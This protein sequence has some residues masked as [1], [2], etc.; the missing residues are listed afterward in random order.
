MAV[1]VEETGRVE[2][3][4]VGVLAMAAGEH[5]AAGRDQCKRR[6]PQKKR[7]RQGR[8]LGLDQGFNTM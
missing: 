8:S 4:V 5:A 3:G 1:A 7:E 6:Q 2:G